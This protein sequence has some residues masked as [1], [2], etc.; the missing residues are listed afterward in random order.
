MENLFNP[1]QWKSNVPSL[2]KNFLGGMNA[3]MDTSWESKYFKGLTVNEENEIFAQCDK[4]NVNQYEKNL[5][6]NDLYKKK[7]QEKTNAK[8]NAEKAEW[9]QELLQRAAEAED[10]TQKNQLNWMARKHEVADMIRNYVLN[11][12]WED[13]TDIDDE[14]LIHDFTQE[15]P[16]AAFSFDEY[17]NWNMSQSYFSKMM[18]FSQ[19]EEEKEQN[20]FMQWLN[21]LWDRFEAFWRWVDNL[22]SKWQAEVDWSWV[23]L[24]A[25]TKYIQDKYW[26]S[27]PAK[28]D[29]ETRDKEYAAVK[30]NPELLKPYMTSTTDDVLDVA[31]WWVDIAFSTFNPYATA[32]FTAVGWL[33]SVMWW[34]ALTRFWEKMWWI[35]SIINE[36]PWLSQF[37]D[38]LSEENQARFDQFV[39]N[40]AMWLMLWVKN[41]SN[42]YKNP[43]Q[44]LIENLQPNQITK[45]FMENVVWISE[46]AYGWL[47]RAWNFA[48]WIEWSSLAKV[49][50]KAS[51][52]LD[53]LSE[54]G[55]E[56]L[57]KTS[58]AQ[59]KLYK[60]QEPR[61]NVLSNKKNLEKRRAN[62][63]RANELIIE[64]WFI[65][66]NTAER[67]DAHQKTLNKL[68]W[69]VMKQV[70]EWEGVFADQS[71]IIDAL[72]NYIKEQEALWIDASKSD[73][74]AL[75]RELD[76]MKKQQREWTLDFPTLEKKKQVFND[77][78][79]WKWVE[80]S[81]VYKKWIRLITHE[82]GKVE[83]AMLSRIPWEFSE[84]KRDVWALLDSY[85][86]VFKAD[87]KNQR[88]KG[89]WLVESYSRIEWIWDTIAGIAQLFRWDISWVAKWLSKVALGKAMAKASDVD[90]LIKKWFSDLY[91]SY[92]KEPFKKKTVADEI[93]TNQAVFDE[94][95]WYIAEVNKW[96]EES[97]VMSLWKMIDENRKNLSLEDYRNLKE[98]LRD[99]TKNWDIDVQ[100]DE[101]LKTEWQDIINWVDSKA[102]KDFQSRI[103][104]IENEE[105]NVGKVAG[106]KVNR[107]YAEQQQRNLE[108]KRE[109]LIEEIWEYYWIDQFEAADKYDQLR[110]SANVN[111]VKFQVADDLEAQY[112]ERFNEN[113][114]DIRF[115]KY[116]TAWQWEKWVTAA[117]WLNI[118]NF[119]NWKSVKELADNYWIKTHIV[120]SISTPEWQKAYGMYWDRVITLARDLKE[121]TVPHELLHATFDMVDQWKKNQIL[122][123]IKKR[124]KVDDVQAEE[125]LADNFSEYYRTGKFD[126]KSIPTTF[127]WKVKQFFQQIK[128]YIDWTYAN[129]KEIQNLFDDI[130]DGKLEWEYWVYS[131]PKFQ[132]VWHGSPAAFEKFDSSHM[133]EWEWAQ[134]HGRGH[135]VAVNKE[136]GEKY[137]NMGKNNWNVM[138]YKGKE[139]DYNTPE[140][141]AAWMIAEKLDYDTIENAKEQ[142]KNELE[143]DREEYA[144]DW[145]TEKVKEIDKMIE[146]IDDITG[147]WSNLY[148]LDIPDP[149]KKD[150]PTGS[151]YLDEFR[152]I[153]DDTIAKFNLALQKVDWEKALDFAI[154]LDK[155]KTA[156]WT[157]N[158]Y[159]EQIYNQLAKVFWSDKKASKFLE[160]LWYDGIHYFWWRDWEAYVIFNDD[161]LKI[162]SHEQ[163]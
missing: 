8:K 43:K 91:D 132:S 122:D 162:N 156:D 154:A 138:Y 57:T 19:A 9:Y 16:Q 11:A 97:D 79:D 161:A 93:K 17:I 99:Q 130:I 18:W 21:W 2:N 39:A 139:V 58:S 104:R 41:K 31:E 24:N 149:I 153:D 55:A 85:E 36:L 131:D 133:W 35:W 86:D 89:N 140:W 141:K 115:Q 90:F 116:W 61:M 125:W 108:A 148:K 113:N 59:D 145:N 37:R 64:N 49:V 96:W 26:V 126:T 32:W 118:R 3:N 51:W 71:S 52:W 135:Y 152:Y 147:G 82:I 80:A 65:P 101:W 54:W 63:D 163:Y 76:S 100:W 38:S 29:K 106:K 110:D 157:T 77:L 88:K 129:R 74:Q 25:Y 143:M 28:L 4:A 142:V 56:K 68:W 127:V 160:S 69:Q 34:W 124:L 30:E 73:I 81:E 111:K 146:S 83:D 48:R 67:L 60:A 151:N 84:L 102:V 13:L 117:E 40:S 121:S 44:F 50:W 98:A 112:S 78:I 92:R 7:I 45:N 62:S 42:I 136:T 137:A 107:A 75:K 10:P 155:L 23:D 95:V 22:L 114:P 120:Q 158:V 123:G 119:K 150:T 87:M 20:W 53:S 46:K 109:R 33:E 134:A 159:W 12:N 6:A 66:K 5:L 103:L 47:Q 14:M 128:E 15:N 94:L 27:Y 72:D 105:K 1:N 70:N 144:E